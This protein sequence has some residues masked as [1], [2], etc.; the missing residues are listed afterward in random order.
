MRSDQSEQTERIR[1]EWVAWRATAAQ[2]YSIE[3]AHLEREQFTTL[4]IM[5]GQRN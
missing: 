3:R 5:A 2:D 4:C 1:E